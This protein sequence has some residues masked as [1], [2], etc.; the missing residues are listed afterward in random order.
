MGSASSVVSTAGASNRATENQQCSS[1][2]AFGSIEAPLLAANAELLHMLTVPAD[3]PPHHCP[4]RRPKLVSGVKH[5]LSGRSMQSTSTS[6][7]AQRAFQIPHV[8]NLILAYSVVSHDNLFA[9]DVRLGS[10][11]NSVDAKWT[12]ARRFWG[13][14]PQRKELFTTSRNW[15]R[16]LP[17]FCWNCQLCGRCVQKYYQTV[18]ASRDGT[19]ALVSDIKNELRNLKQQGV[20]RRSHAQHALWLKGRRLRSDARKLAVALST[21][22]EWSESYGHATDCESYGTASMR[23]LE[24]VRFEH[25]P[26]DR[27]FDSRLIV[28]HSDLDKVP[29]AAHRTLEP[30]STS[31][32]NSIPLWS[33]T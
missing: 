8:R 25:R 13:L 26:A 27:Q 14:L 16:P 29:A 11:L 32:G 2:N 4:A 17:T 7:A 30:W 20:H 15:S 12:H 18:N 19:F 23:H 1:Q 28:Y 6:N 24:I 9:L 31:F 21:R 3:G 10:I 5:L 33:R 22:G